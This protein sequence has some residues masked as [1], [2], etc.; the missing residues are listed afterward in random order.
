MFGFLAI[1]SFVSWMTR[2][3]PLPYEFFFPRY[4]G[5]S[6]IDREPGGVNLAE[7]VTNIVMISN[8]LDI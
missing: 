1:K 3:N 5:H 4:S 8:D 6:L 2:I 7:K